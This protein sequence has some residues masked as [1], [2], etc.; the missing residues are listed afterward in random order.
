[1]LESVA[2]TIDGSVDVM[3]HDWVELGEQDEEL[4]SVSLKP[5]D[6]TGHLQQIRFMTCSFASDS[7]TARTRKL[8]GINRCQAPRRATT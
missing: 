8:F 2:A 7:V 5:A 3:I 4:T 1:M 6:R